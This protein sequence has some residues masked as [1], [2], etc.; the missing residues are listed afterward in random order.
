MSC[1][2]PTCRRVLAVVWKTMAYGA[3]TTQLCAQSP[4]AK[5][6]AIPQALAAGQPVA[7]IERLPAE[8]T[9]PID[10]ESIQ[11]IVREELEAERARASD[12]NVLT[13]GAASSSPAEPTTDTKKI[14]VGKDRS[15]EPE[16]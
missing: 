1:F 10:R 11:R 2:M 6:S 8:S 4:P 9:V 7:H 3:V 16:W 5:P 12:S 13:A 15:L 14:E